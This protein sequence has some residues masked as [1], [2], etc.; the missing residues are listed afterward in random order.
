[1]YREKFNFLLEHI[2]KKDDGG[3][4]AHEKEG[5]ARRSVF[6]ELTAFFKVRFCSIV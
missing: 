6:S 1:M 5:K 2:D 3:A 4:R